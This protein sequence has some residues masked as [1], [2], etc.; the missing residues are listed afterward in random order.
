MR[1]SCIATV[2]VFY[3]ICNFQNLRYHITSGNI[4]TSQMQQFRLFGRENF[5]KRPTIIT[6]AITK[7]LSIPREKTLEIGLRYAKFANLFCY[8][9]K[10]SIN[11]SCCQYYVHRSC[12]LCS[13]I[14]KQ[15]SQFLQLP[16]MLQRKQLNE[17]RII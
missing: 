9:D 7:I 5:G 15:F 13:C 4:G 8:V 10:I 2:H 3:F 1:Y 14:I 11:F 16:V 17:W 6:I 12:L